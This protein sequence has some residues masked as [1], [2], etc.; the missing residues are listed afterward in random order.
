MQISRSDKLKTKL[1]SVESTGDKAREYKRRA[2]EL[3]PK[4]RQLGDKENRAKMSPDGQNSR[5]FTEA[6][7]FPK[8]K[9]DAK[10]QPAQKAQMEAKMRLQQP[11]SADGLQNIIKTYGTVPLSSGSKPFVPPYTQSQSYP[12]S[13]KPSVPSTRPQTRQSSLNI[14]AFKKRETVN[15]DLT[16]NDEEEGDEDLDM[17]LALSAR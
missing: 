17:A 15:I 1:L 11:A 14:T 10:P 6:V 12:L 16:E 9:A 13:L 4:L 3:E 5:A 2:K 8:K 7:L